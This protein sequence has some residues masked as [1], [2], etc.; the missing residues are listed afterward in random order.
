MTHDARLKEQPHH[1][2]H[3]PGRR[4]ASTLSR[5][6]TIE[7]FRDAKFGMFIHWGVYALLGK[8]EWIRRVGK[9]P[10]AAHA[11]LRRRFDP[12]K[13]DPGARAELAEGA[14]TKYMI[15]TTK[16]LDGGA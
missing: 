7:W 2:T 14:G 6:Y 11:T 1:A 9:I 4:H 15:F 10:R 13:F 12:T 8:G 5:E 16:H 3:R